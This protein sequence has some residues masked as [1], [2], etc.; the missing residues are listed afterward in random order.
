MAK[1]DKSLDFRF[2]FFLGV[3]TKKSLEME[4][5]TWAGTEYVKWQQKGWELPSRF[6]A[7]NCLFAQSYM[8]EKDLPSGRKRE[9]GKSVEKG[10]FLAN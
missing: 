6:S 3:F 10:K 8:D 4:S 9:N 2:G 7:S 1:N 5:F